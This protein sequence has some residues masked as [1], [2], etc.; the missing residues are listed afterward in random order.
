MSRAADGNVF[1]D[2][3]GTSNLTTNNPYD[4]LLEACEQDTVIISSQV[5]VAGKLIAPETNSAS[6]SDASR[7]SKRPAEKKAALSRFFRIYH[8]RS[9]AQ[10]GQPRDKS[11]IRRSEKLPS[12]L[13]K[14]T[15]TYSAAR[16]VSTEAV[17]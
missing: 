13:G 15:K 1:A 6:L 7:D 11:R 12:L 9:A 2:L 5:R 17:T 3:S 16:G 10:A 8:R 14:A 4:A